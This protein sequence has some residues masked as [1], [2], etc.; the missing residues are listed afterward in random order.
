MELPALCGM[1]GEPTARQS[2]ND[3]GD[4]GDGTL[5][6]CSSVSAVELTTAT[7]Q[8][9]HISQSPPGMQCEVHA[10]NALSKSAQIVAANR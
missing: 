4:D 7:A 3:D 1:E 6:D 2:C 8:N 9:A 5:S 10:R